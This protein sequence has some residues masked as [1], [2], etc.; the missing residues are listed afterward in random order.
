MVG[1]LGHD[2]RARRGV[3]FDHFVTVSTP[4]DALN[5]LLT[6]GT[7]VDH[8]RL[9]LDSELGRRGVRFQTG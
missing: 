9:R 2:E 6:D 1:V 3:N 4:V 5:L 7:G 8:G